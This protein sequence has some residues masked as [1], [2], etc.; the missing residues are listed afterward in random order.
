MPRSWFLNVFKLDV[1][2]FF[3]ARVVDVPRY[4]IAWVRVH[5]AVILPVMLREKKS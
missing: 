2:A 5:K 4:G 1:A 3:Y